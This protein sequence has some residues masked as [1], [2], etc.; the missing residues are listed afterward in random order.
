M[1]TMKAVIVKPQ[2]DFGI[3]NVPIPQCP[4]GG[5]LLR[6][7]ACGL[8]GSYLRTL[9]SGH[10]KVVFHWII[11]HEI[12]GVIVETGRRYRSCWR[13]GD[14]LSVTPL[15]YCG[16]CHFCRAGRHELC[17]DY[18]EI[19]Q[20]WPGGFAEYLAIPE[21]AILHGAIRSVPEGLDMDLAAIAANHS[22]RFSG[23]FYR[24]RRQGTQR[25]SVQGDYPSVGDF[26]YE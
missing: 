9:R 26:V 11:G 5:L 24:H 8:C 25:R 23:G 20:A 18:R 12:S 13:K 2:M 1:T 14:R 22:S 21:E 6:V 15:V 3:E 7:S 19:A 17:E 16:Q 10:R 4:T